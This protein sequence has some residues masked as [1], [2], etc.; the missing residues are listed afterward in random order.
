MENNT[1]ALYSEIFV[2]DDET[3]ETMIG[4]YYPYDSMNLNWSIMIQYI[5]MR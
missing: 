1:D 4:G 2:E 5:M 3:D